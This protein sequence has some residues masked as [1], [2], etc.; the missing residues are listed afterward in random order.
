[1]SISTPTAAT[2][3]RRTISQSTLRSLNSQ[4]TARPSRLTQRPCRRGTRET[5]DRPS[6]DR[7][8]RGLEALA[9]FGEEG[10]PVS[11]VRPLSARSPESPV[12]RPFGV[13]RGSTLSPLSRHPR[14]PAGNLGS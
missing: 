4:N 14:L 10:R 2:D 7:D 11:A 3:S 9:R 1:L 8:G 12:G 6:R 13:C 5:L